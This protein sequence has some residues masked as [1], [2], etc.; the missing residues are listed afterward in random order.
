[1]SVKLE[2]RGAVLHITIDRAPVR[3][4]LDMAAL[5]G[6]QEALD[7]LDSDPELRVGVL[8]GAGDRIFCSGADLAAIAG[9]GLSPAEAMHRYAVVLGRIL[10][11]RRPLIARLGGHVLGGGVG[12][13]LACDLAVVADPVQISLP[14]AAVGMWPMMVGA[15]LLR[16]LPRK[17]ALELA[18]TGRKLSAMEALK[19][20]L[21]NRVVPPAELDDQVGALCD[22]VQRMSPSALR[23]GR[24]AWQ[25]SLGQSPEH[26][27]VELAAALGALA[28]T[29]DAAEGMMAFFEKRTPQWKDR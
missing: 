10:A 26:A 15:L 21:L 2:K 25:R 8:T 18:L 27:L 3:N 17:Q 5:E 1:M 28:S 16:D 7:Q 24:A 14:E 23:L 4:A 13:L 22:A 9:S 11:C 6:L 29:E 12:L 19:L 20:G